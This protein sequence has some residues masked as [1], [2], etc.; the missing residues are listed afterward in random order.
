M[1][2]NSMCRHIKNLCA[3]FFHDAPS[4]VPALQ[5]KN[6]QSQPNEIPHDNV[7]LWKTCKNCAGDYVRSFLRAKLTHFE[8]F[9]HL[10]YVELC[11]IML[12]YV[13]LCWIML[14]Y[15]ESLECWANGSLDV[16]LRSWGVVERCGG[17]SFWTLRLRFMLCTDI[18]GSQ[19][20]KFAPPF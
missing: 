10:K 3:F 16:D 12:N 13:E 20:A 11:R 4:R 14:N 6:G 18:L 5:A 1:F 8:S 19:P 2:C 7:K 17:Q 9:W 15:V